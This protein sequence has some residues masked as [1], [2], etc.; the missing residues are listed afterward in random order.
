MLVYTISSLSDK[1]LTLFNTDGSDTTKYFLVNKNLKHNMNSE[2]AKWGNKVIK[3]CT[4]IL[5][6]YKIDFYPFQAKFNEI[7]NTLI[8]GLN[9]ASNGYDGTIETYNEPNEFQLSIEKIFDGNLEYVKNKESWKIYQNLMKIDFFKNLSTDFNYMN[10]VYFPTPKFYDIKKIKD[11]DVIKIC[12]SLTLDLIK[13]IN[14]KIIIVLGT[15]SGIDVIAKNTQTILTGYR[16]R[17]LVQGEIEGITAFGIPHPSYNNF[18][19]ENEEISEVLQTL[20][21][22]KKVMPYNL[23]KP[24]N[25]EKKIIKKETFEIQRL[26]DNLNQFND[27]LFQEFNNKKHLFNASIKGENDTLDFRIDIR[28]GYFAFRSLDKVNNSFFELKGKENYRKLFSENA[29]LEKKSWLVYKTFQ[30]YNANESIEDQIS[31]DLKKIILNIE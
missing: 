10:Y 24:E 25:L 3:D 12:K 28:D 30:N 27:F 13:I 11:F 16:K 18:Q 5:Q 23:S 26:N 6:K 7:S 1:E 4:P 20:I 19:A 8:I 31:N 2:L 21:N 22:G 17:L 14:P 15:G 29:E 9:P